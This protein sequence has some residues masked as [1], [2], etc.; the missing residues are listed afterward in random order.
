MN[1]EFVAQQASRWSAAIIRNNPDEAER[2]S[3]MYQA[4]FARPA[5]PDELEKIRSF[6]HSQEGR[7]ENEVWADVAHVLLNS[8]EFIYLR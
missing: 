8:P 3:H 2:I 4:A 7:A 5:A 1:N 6:I